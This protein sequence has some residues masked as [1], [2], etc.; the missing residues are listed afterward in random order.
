MVQKVPHLGTDAV[1][2]KSAEELKVRMVCFFIFKPQLCLFYNRKDGVNVTGGVSERSDDK[3]MLNGDRDRA[4]S[5]RDRAS[6]D[7]DRVSSDSNQQNEEP[8]FV[9]R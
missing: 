2:Q 7:G 6:S 4:S 8:A 5:D 3:A 1:Y 9:I